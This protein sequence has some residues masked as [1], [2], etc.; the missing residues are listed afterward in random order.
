MTSSSRDR[1]LC[2]ISCLGFSAGIPGLAW[3]I[4]LEGVSFLA[5]AAVLAGLVGMTG[6]TETVVSALG[7]TKLATFVLGGALYVWA[8]DVFLI[9]I[10]AAVVEVPQSGQLSLYRGRRRPHFRQNGISSL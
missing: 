10:I 3:G 5:G 2:L 9:L 4:G 6:L 7:I 8:A 1:L